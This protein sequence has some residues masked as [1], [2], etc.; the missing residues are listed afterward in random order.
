M[1]EAH[2]RGAVIAGCSAGA[3]VLGGYQPQIGGRGFLRPPFGWQEGLGLAPGLVIIPH[4]DAAPEYSTVI[5]PGM[6]ARV[7][8]YGNLLVEVAQ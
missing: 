2:A 5:E 8:A 6:H 4:Y 1:R 7:D 3:M